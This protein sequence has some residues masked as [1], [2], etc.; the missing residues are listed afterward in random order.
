M[1]HLYTEYT[2]ENISKAIGDHNAVFR[3]L[4][5][6]Q[7]LDEKDINYLYEIDRAKIIDRKMLTIETPYGVC[8]IDRIS[9]GLKVILNFRC[10]IKVGKQD[11]LVDI[12]S[13]GDNIIPYLIE[14]ARQAKGDVYWLTANNSTICSKETEMVVNDK[15]MVKSFNDLIFMKV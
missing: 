13:C 4:T 7:G 1:I 8:G 9:R 12:T 2:E 15:I 3:A 5:L 10:L 11:T 14:E 6:P